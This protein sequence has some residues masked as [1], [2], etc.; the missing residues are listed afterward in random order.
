MSSVSS[1]T[2]GAA[3]GVGG[4]CMAFHLLAAQSALSRISP[5]VLSCP[6]S[7]RASQSSSRII[8]RSQSRASG[9]T[10]V[11]MSSRARS[12]VGLRSRSLTS[13]SQDAVAFGRNAGAGCSGPSWL[14]SGS[15]PRSRAHAAGPFGY[16]DGGRRRS[17][18]DAE[19]ISGLAGAMAKTTESKPSSFRTN[20]LAGSLRWRLPTSRRSRSAHVRRRRLRLFGTSCIFC[21]LP[22]F[23]KGWGRQWTGANF[24]VLPA[25]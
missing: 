19:I 10:R 1:G 20:L 23:P 12:R 17:H 15:R 18:P 16:H 3:A 6:T 8:S 9:G 21:F 7:R 11:S 4:T 14:S 22:F 25:E 2:P 24:S 5:A 13:R